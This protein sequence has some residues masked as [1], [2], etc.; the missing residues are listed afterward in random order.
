MPVGAWGRVTHQQV[1]P[2]RWKARARF[3]D[4][5]GSTRLVERWGATGAS[6]ERALKTAMLGRSDHDRS[7]TAVMTVSEL[8]ADWLA[9]VRDRGRAARTIEQYERTVRGHVIPRLGKLRVHE[10]TPHVVDQVLRQVRSDVGPAAARTMRSVLSGLAS[11]AVRRGHLRA[12]PVRDAAPIARS[13]N[14]RAPRALTVEE[15]GRLRTL[16][17][18]DRRAV[19]LDLPDLVDCMLMTGVRLGEACAIREEVVDVER[20]VLEINAQIIRATGQGIVLQPR[21]KSA[22]GWRRIAIPSELLAIIERRQQTAWLHNPHRAIFTSAHG[23]LRDP[24]NTTGDLREILD[25]LGFPWVSSH[26]FRKTVATRL[27]ELGKTP[28]QIADQL[29]HEHPS[30]T[31]DVYMGRRA[32]MADTAEALAL[33]PINDE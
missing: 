18:A 10:L 3:R 19:D 11:I 8:A 13:T 29:G 22:A 27:D 16:L 25:R 24:S 33:P 7:T 28:R 20:G 6:A 31:L 2:G 17:R 12:N 23:Y 4:L 26:T 21:P 1:G 5:D 14:S 9:E 30:M 32:V 15:T